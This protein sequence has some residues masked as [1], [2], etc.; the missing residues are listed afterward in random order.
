MVKFELG[1]KCT[2]I[3]FDQFFFFK[4]AMITAE[5]RRNTKKITKNMK[6]NSCYR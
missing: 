1:A 3:K 4:N 6:Y 5:Q 2:E